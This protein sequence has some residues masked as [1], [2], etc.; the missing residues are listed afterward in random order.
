MQTYIYIYIY[1]YIYYMCIHIHVSEIATRPL[2]E[3]ISLTNK[4]SKKPLET[5]STILK[6]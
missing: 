5:V 3:T 2:D 4:P 6:L 1:M